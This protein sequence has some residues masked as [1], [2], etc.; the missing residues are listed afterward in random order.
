MTYKLSQELSKIVSPILLKF[1][2]EERNLSFENGRALA[3][4]EFE[5]GY[6]VESL[7]AKEGCIVLTIREND[8][9]NGITWSGEEAVS[10]F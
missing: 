1:A 3:A 8:K 2:G 5:K 10:F 7:E 6:L 9:V 4:A